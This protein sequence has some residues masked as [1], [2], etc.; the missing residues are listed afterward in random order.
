MEKY[1]KEYIQNKNLCI[2]YLP[3]NLY[4]I[5]YLCKISYESKLLPVLIIN[6]NIYKNK[7]D[8]HNEHNEIDFVLNN[9]NKINIKM[10]KSRRLFKDDKASTFLIEI[11]PNKDKIELDYFFDLDKFINENKKELN[12]INFNMFKLSKED[13]IYDNN[14]VEAISYN[15]FNNFKN[16]MTIKYQINNEEN[17]RIFGTRFVKNNKGNCLLYINNEKKELTEILNINNKNGNELEIKLEEI[18]PINN[19]SYIFYECSSLIDL[20]DISNWISIKVNNMSNMFYGCKS[21]K[22]LDGI[23]DWFTS[24]VINMRNIFSGCIKLKYIPDISKWDTS[25]VIDMSN[26]F[27]ECKGLT[28]LP[29]ISK[30]NTSNI[31]DM[32]N[33]FNGCNLLKSLPD[34]SKWDISKVEKF[35]KMFFKCESLDYL[36][37][38]SNWNTSNLKDIRYLFCE[39]KKLSSLPDISKWNTLNLEEINYLFCECKNLFSLPDISNW[40]TSNIKDMNNLFNGCISLNSLPDISKWDTSNVEN[41]EKMFY[42]CKKISSLPNIGNWKTSHLKYKNSM[43]KGCKGSLKIDKKFLE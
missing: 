7:I 16:K 2:I 8:V 9:N 43:F 31:I 1:K 23:S 13:K 39:C 30:W 34:I 19:M 21:L 27:Y 11:K 26:M 10:T 32:S 36:P 14:N 4:E 42:Q 22:S 37:D 15:L 20:P 18:K 25:S 40:N 12:T 17:I 35:C 38:I 3:N 33:M 28:S 24:N 5:G 29:D 6:N 41:M